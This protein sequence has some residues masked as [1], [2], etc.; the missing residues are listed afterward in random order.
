MEG[1]KLRVWFP[2][3]GKQNSRLLSIPL[4]G[5]HQVVNAATAYATLDIFHQK[6]FDID[7][8]EIIEGFDK[9]FWPGRFEIIQNSPPVILDCAH[10]RDSASKLP[11]TLEDNSP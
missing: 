8:N 11:L 9:A 5:P 2:G 3:Q 4:L 6:G 7:Q 1:Q 10:N